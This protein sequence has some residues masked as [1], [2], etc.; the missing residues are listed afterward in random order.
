MKGISELADLVRN[1]QKELAYQNAEV[2][3]IQTLI[4]NCAS[5]HM[6][7]VVDLNTCQYASPCFKGESK[8]F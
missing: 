7:A 5:C 6:G 2:K 8:A 4:E 3:H 1:V